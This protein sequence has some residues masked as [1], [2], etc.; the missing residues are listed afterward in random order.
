[1]RLI[2]R[3]IGAAIFLAGF[4]VLAR[5]VLRW[6]GSGKWS[7]KVVGELWFELDRGSLNLAQAVIQRYLHPSLWDP[8]VTGLLLCWAFGVLMALGLVLMLLCR[9]RAPSAAT[10]AGARAGRR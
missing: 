6:S 7:P 10:T 5:D 9:A 4:I 3:L 2:G 1:M 8:V